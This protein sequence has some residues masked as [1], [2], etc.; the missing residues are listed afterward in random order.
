MLMRSAWGVG[1]EMMAQLASNY[2]LLKN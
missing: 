1:S 2:Y